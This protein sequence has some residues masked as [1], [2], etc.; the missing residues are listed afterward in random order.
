RAGNFGARRPEAADRVPKRATGGTGLSLVDVIGRHDPLHH[1]GYDR[2]HRAVSDP[3]RHDGRTVG[4]A[5]Q[6][7]VDPGK[8]GRATEAGRSQPEGDGRPGKGSRRH[9]ELQAVERRG[10]RAGAWNAGERCGRRHAPMVAGGCVSLEGRDRPPT[11]TRRRHSAALR[12]QRRT[13]RVRA[14]MLAP[15]LSTVEVCPAEM[16]ARCVASDMTDVS[17]N[18]RTRVM[19]APEFAVRL[20]HPNEVGCKAPDPRRLLEC[21]V[22]SILVIDGQGRI[23]YANSAALAMNPRGPRPN[24]TALDLVHPDDR[25]RITEVFV[26]LLQHPGGSSVT[27]LRVSVQGTWMPVEVNAINLLDDPAVGGIVAC[28]RNLTVQTTTARVADRLRAALEI[29]PDLVLIHDGEG[30]VIHANR[31]ARSFFDLDARPEGT[32]TA[33]DLYPVSAKHLLG[34]GVGAAVPFWAGEVMFTSGEG[35][36]IDASVVMTTTFNDDG[37]VESYA[38]MGRDI[39]DQKLIQSALSHRATHDPLTGLA[40]RSALIERLAG[41]LQADDSPGLLAVLF[42][43]LDN[44][45]IVNDTLGHDRGDQLLI[46]V[47]ARLRSAVRPDDLVARI[48]GDEF[49]AVMPGLTSPD[50]ARLV[51]DRVAR[52]IAAPFDLDGRKVY[53]TAS[54]GIA[55]D[56]EEGERTPEGLVRNSDMAMYQAKARGR[57]RSEFFDSSMQRAAR[58]RLDLE[59][60]LHQAIERGELTVAYQPIFSLPDRRLTGFEA[61]MRWQHPVLGEMM[62]DEFL[63]VADQ[64]GLI[65]LADTAVLVKACSD[66]AAWGEQFDMSRLNVAVNLSPRQLSRCDLPEL[67]A[68]TIAMTGIEADRLTLEITEGRL[69]DDVPVTLDMLRRLRELGVLLAIDDFGTGH[70]SLGYLR[71]FDVHVM[72]ID[73]SFVDAMERDPAS[74]VII[75]AMVRLADTYGLRVVAEGVETEQQLQELV[76]LGCGAAQGFLLGPPMVADR[77][78]ELLSARL[79]SAMVDLRTADP[80]ASVHNSPA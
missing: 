30:V 79:P 33:R 15:G 74:R 57:N 65:S 51:A 8:P 47:T 24:A 71:Q 6:R 37:C 54:I 80:V 1:V 34:P 77:V 10:R 60:E 45:K 22:D 58:R 9:G 11:L 3:H 46:A 76:A 36:V 32:V 19:P 64:A 29:T 12:A 27:A 31:A 63:A 53:V 28:F 40:N 20:P 69:M 73:R 21:V 13:R 59:S 23:T 49:V 75:E 17:P 55:F 52:A 56:D 7:T 67:V 44:F 2:R 18:S 61:L 43:D 48:G 66:F 35:R 14:V 41:E 26:G 70:S 25:D 39:S 50:V 38:V 62:P 5:A 16:R 4:P 78:V 72:K 68:E 42:V